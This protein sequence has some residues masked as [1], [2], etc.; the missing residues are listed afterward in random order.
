MF[1]F[2]KNFSSTTTIYSLFLLALA[3]AE[4]GR[5]PPSEAKNI[6]LRSGDPADSRKNQLIARADPPAIFS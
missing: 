2:L 3:Q 4:P 6:R 1:S 5:F